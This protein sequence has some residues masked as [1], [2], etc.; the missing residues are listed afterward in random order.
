MEDEEEED[1][2]D[3]V[4]LE[5]EIMEDVPQ[6]EL[7]AS[8][9]ELEAEEAVACPGPSCPAARPQPPDEEQAGSQLLVYVQTLLFLL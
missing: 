4:M 6:D 9:R 5:E 7:K 2:E 8:E 3:E 1:D